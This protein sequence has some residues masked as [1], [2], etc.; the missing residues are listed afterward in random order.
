LGSAR[1]ILE[2]ELMLTI[3]L[4]ELFADRGFALSGLAFRRDET[5]NLALEAECDLAHL[6]VREHHI[7][8]K[9][10]TGN[11]IVRPLRSTVRKREQ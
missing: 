4:E 3:A 7:V 10:S 2:D 9:P 5:L 11:E 1:T 6:D 8:T